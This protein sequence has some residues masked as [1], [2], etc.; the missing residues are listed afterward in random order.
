MNQL[1]PEALLARSKKILFITHLAIG[2][3]TYLQNYFKLFSE[4]Y[5]HIK[6]DL[7]VDEVRRTRCFWYWGG[8]KNY[9]LFDW[10]KTSGLFNKIYFGTYSWGRFYKI[11]RA[12][13][14][15]EYPIVISLCTLRSRFYV[16]YSR[17]V[18]QD[19]FV[20]GV[21]YERH[22]KLRSTK[23]LDSYVLISASEKKSHVSLTYQEWFEKL[24]GLSVNP[25]QREPFVHIPKEW[26]SYGKLKF[27]QWG[28]RN[29][30]YEKVV[31]INSFA[32]NV[33][34]CWPIDRVVKLIH[35]L[36]KLEGYEDAYF[37]I[38][39]EPH[40]YGSVRDLF[41]NFCLSRVILFT[42]HTN[43]FQLP[44]IMS[45]CD[46]VISVETSIIHLASALKIPVVALMRQK[47]PEW[48][49]FY[50]DQSIV[51]SAKNR[52]DWVEDIPLKTVINGVK[53]FNLTL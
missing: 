30:R 6:I 39:V 25:V 16:K 38:N 12:A 29:K 18:S 8:M 43:F 10:V 48:C 51:I 47:T 53:G 52:R 17:H 34:R 50:K 9:V 35:A 1:V 37:I 11:F 45:L 21:V 14:S 20:S 15:E 23:K 44:A 31:F 28:I 42:A 33:L 2:D 3:F 13:R 49:P 40:F 19:G 41:S 46:L 24:F 27:T 22:K 26:V 36:Q 4:K 5:P 7:W 32:K